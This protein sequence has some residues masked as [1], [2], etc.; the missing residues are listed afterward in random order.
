ASPLPY[1]PHRELHSFPTRRS[2]DLLL[3]L[4]ARQP[5][6]PTVPTDTAQTSPVPGP[7]GDDSPRPAFERR[8]AWAAGSRRTRWRDG[9]PAAFAVLVLHAVAGVAALRGLGVVEPEPVITPPAITGY[10]SPKR[11]ANWPKRRP[12]RRPRPPRRLGK[13]RRRIPRWC[14]RPRPRNRSRSPRRL[15]RRSRS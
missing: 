6:G 5:A 3:L 4:P 15:L 7:Y 11:R 13:C 2:S 1:P 14:R 10:W 9:I 8:P 12:R